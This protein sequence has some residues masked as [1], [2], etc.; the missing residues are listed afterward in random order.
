LIGLYV[1]IANWCN[2]GMQ[3]YW[4]ASQYCVAGRVKCSMSK[5][6]T[7]RKKYYSLWSTW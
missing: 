2:A 7:L 3:P 4:P 6:T 1:R 5:T